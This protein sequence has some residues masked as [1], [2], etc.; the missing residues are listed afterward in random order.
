M[1]TSAVNPIFKDASGAALPVGLIE[2]NSMQVVNQLIGVGITVAL[3][4]VGS[5]LILKFVDIVIGL[6]VSELEE[7]AGLDATQHGETAYVFEP[8]GEN[9]TPPNYI[10]TEGAE[11]S[12]RELVLE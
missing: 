5:I 7:T 2:G 9:S 10:S 12:S 6:R 11:L 4:S 1:A 8:I 3:A